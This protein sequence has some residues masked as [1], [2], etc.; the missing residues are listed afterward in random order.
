MELPIAAP[1]ARPARGRKQR[2]SHAELARVAFRLFAEKGFEQ[3]TIDDIAE[4]AGIGRRTFFN[5][6]AS[7]NDLVWGDFDEHLARF[8]RLLDEVPPGMPLMTA[9]R[10]AVVA[11]NDYDASRLPDHRRR[12]ALILDVPALQA[13]STL[14]YAQWQDA[15]SGF[16][17]RRTG[18][19]EH[20]LVPR[21][22]GA[23]ALSSAITAY[24]LWLDD[25]SSDLPTL[26]GDALQLLGTG[27]TDEVLAAEPEAAATPHRA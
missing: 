19:P 16:A 8:R 18:H 3:T 12:M 26:I 24:R 22:M 27:L 25:E 10:T 17:A 21:L 20:S 9:L 2:T 4:A 15:V 11:F 13:D 5:Y 23:I 14:R 7:K 6:Y 1:T